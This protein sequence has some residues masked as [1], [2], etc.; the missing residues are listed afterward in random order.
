MQNGNETEMWTRR[1]IMSALLLAGLTVA[2]AGGWLWARSNALARETRCLQE[3]EKLDK[4]K[5]HIQKNYE[6]IFGSAKEKSVASPLLQKPMLS[7]VKDVAGQCGMANR[8]QRIVEEENKKLN[9][10]TAKVTLRRVRIADTVNFLT[11]ARK[12]YPGL[13]DREGRMRYSRGGD[14]DS[15]DVTLSLTA[16]KP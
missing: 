7:I 14:A 10:L 3:E 8:I 5:T 6:M 12:A 15:W 9:E 2:L 4:V 1:R 11:I 13:W 16:Q